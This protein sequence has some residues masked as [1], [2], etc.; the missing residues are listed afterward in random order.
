MIINKDVMKEM[1]FSFL[2]GRKLKVIN[3]S[4]RSIEIDEVVI[5]GCDY[6]IGYTLVDVSDRTSYFVCQRGPSV[7]RRFKI[8]ETYERYDGDFHT[9]INN[10]ISKNV[11]DCNMDENLN[12]LASA[13]T[14]AFV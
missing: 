6:N 13:D 1:D 10:V 3:R 2:E 11:Y 9:F 7:W 5:V 8:L 4:P 12:D 14:C